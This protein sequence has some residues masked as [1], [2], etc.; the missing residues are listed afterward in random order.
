[1]ADAAAHPVSVRRDDGTAVAKA[2]SMDGFKVGAP[3]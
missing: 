3:E 2:A 1:M